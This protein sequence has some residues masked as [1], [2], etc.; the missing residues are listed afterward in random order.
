MTLR[1]SNL[2]QVIDLSQRI[3]A[4]S[5]DPRAVAAGRRVFDRLE[6]AEGAL[7]AVAAERL[8]A[9]HHN[10]E[11]ALA[12]LAAQASPL[13]EL[14]SAFAAVEGGL[15]WVRRKTAEAVGEPFFSGHANAL[16]VGPG[17]LEQRDDVWIGV[18]VMAPQIVYPDH[19]HPPEEV[20]IA[21][22]PGEWWNAEMD[23]TAPGPG[24]VIYNPRGIRHAMRSHA[25]PFLALW[26][27]PI[28]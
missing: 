20:Y 21:L 11:A 17:G 13:P 5:T 1:D 24:G 14:G 16:L 18:T 19:D 6:A 3:I 23:W 25:S 4:A 22:T 27:L 9:C 26:F 12:G 15:E 2:Q 28:D 7:G 10:V 8:P